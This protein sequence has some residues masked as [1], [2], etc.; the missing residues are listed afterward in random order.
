M[1]INCRKKEATITNFVTGENK[2]ITDQNKKTKDKLKRYGMEINRLLICNNQL[3]EK[4]E[5]LEKEI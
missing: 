4:V 1:M 2:K 3:Q 5:R